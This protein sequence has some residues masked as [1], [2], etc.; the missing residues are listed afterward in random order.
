MR[1]KVGES[2]VSTTGD[3]DTVPHPGCSEE[4]I[5]DIGGALE[6]VAGV[7]I[8]VGGLADVVDLSWDADGFVGA[9][10]HQ[11]P[12]RSRKILIGEGLQERCHCWRHG[13][14]GGTWEHNKAANDHN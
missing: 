3:A 5:D 1:V 13:L 10:E 7:L 4:L 14:K 6:L 12:V 2:T 9:G 11:A 8:Q